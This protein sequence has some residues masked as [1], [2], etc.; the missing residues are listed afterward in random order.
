[1]TCERAFN[2]YFGMPSYGGNGG[3]SSEVPDIRQWYARLML[4]LRDDP[5]VNEVHEATIG[6]TPITMVRNRFVL[7]ARARKCDILVMVDSD[8]NPNLHLGQPGYKP[9]WESS[10]DFLCQ[11]YQRGPCVIGSPY[12]GPPGNRGSE[13]MYV[14]EWQNSGD[15]GDESIF[16]LSQIPRMMAARM[17]GIQPCAALPTGMIMYDMRVFDLI[18]PC[19]LST[20]DVLEQLVQ[21]KINK[22]EAARML[23]PGFFYYEWTNNY[24]AEKASTEDVTNTR[25]ISL[26]GCVKYGYNPVYCNWDAPVGHW[27]PWCVSGKPSAYCAENIAATFREVVL[28]DVHT[29]EAEVNAASISGYKE[30]RSWPSPMGPTALDRR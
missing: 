20:E 1:M 24:A 27:K 9:F 8:T 16:E 29:D 17:S 25:D 3:I 11:H 7:E 28:R 14:F 23:R 22:H 13:N 30:S 2:V 12:C 21:G 10:F 5:R 6:D 4:T 19:Q 18:E 15:H 26:A